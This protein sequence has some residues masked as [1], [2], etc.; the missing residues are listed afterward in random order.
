MF[1]GALAPIAGHG[2][3][4]V[5]QAF[6][7]AQKEGD[8]AVQHEFALVHD[9]GQGRVGGDAKAGLI[10]Q[11]ADMGNAAPGRHLRPAL[12]GRGRQPD[13]HARHAAQRADAAHGGGRTEHAALVHE[14]RREIGDQDGRAVL[15][16]QLGLQHGGIADIALAR[17]GQPGQGDGKLSGAAQQRVEH[18]LTVQPRQAEPAHLALFADQGRDGAIADDAEFQ[19]GHDRLSSS[20]RQSASGSARR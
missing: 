19:G 7:R 16:L 8:L 11:E 9:Q 5:G 18:G 2:A 4:G 17:G 12:A 1:A 13:R 15:G 14:A 20:Q 6:I 10:V 3:D